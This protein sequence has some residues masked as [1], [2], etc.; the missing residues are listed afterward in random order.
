[1]DFYLLLLAGGRGERMQSKIPKQFLKIHG[2]PLWLYSLE[3]FHKAIPQLRTIIVCISDYQSQLQ[4]DLASWGYRAVVVDGG[5]TRTLSVYNGLKYLATHACDTKALIA[6][7]D[8]ARPLITPKHIQKAFSAAQQ[9]GSAVCVVPIRFA[10]RKKHQ[11]TT[12][13]VDR[14]LYLEVQTPQIFPFEPLWKAYQQLHH[15]TFYDDASLMEAWGYPIHIV[16]GDPY[17]IKVTYEKDLTIVK[18][19]LNA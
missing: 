4:K 6:I 16:E 18:A 7:H 11:N 13:S 1:M 10:L 3:S 17:N 12:I 9:Y 14:S 2:K 15:Q 19:L 8:S 5:S